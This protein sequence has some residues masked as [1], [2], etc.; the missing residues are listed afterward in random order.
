MFTD[1]D[2]EQVKLKNLIETLILGHTVQW[3][4]VTLPKKPYLLHSMRCP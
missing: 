2:P 3:S 1:T 4:N